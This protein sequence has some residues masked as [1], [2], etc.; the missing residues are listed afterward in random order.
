MLIHLAILIY[1]II[2][3][4]ETGASILTSLFF[5]LIFGEIIIKKL[6]SFQPNGQP[7]RQDGPENHIIEKAGTPT[8]G[9]V[10][11]L[12]SMTISLFLWADFSNKFVWICFITSILFGLI[13]FFDDYLKL[14]YQ[15][16]KGLKASTKFYI[17]YC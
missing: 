4:L 15:N 11:I 9:G 12:S 6:V 14:K 2:S 1:L 8:M 3:H 13:G 16:H 10:L 5:S 7:I 17:N